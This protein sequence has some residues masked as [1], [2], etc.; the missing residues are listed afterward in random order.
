MPKFHEYQSKP[1]GYIQTSIDGTPQTL[2]VSPSAGTLLKELGFEYG[3]YIPRDV[4]KPLIIVGT[5]GTKPHGRT[6]WELLDGIPELSTEYCELNESQQEKLREYL[7]QRVGDL[8]EPVFDR[9]ATFIETE[10]PLESFSQTKISIKETAEGGPAELQIPPTESD[11]DLEAI[12]AELRRA[13]SWLCWRRETRDSKPTKVPISPH[14]GEFG[15]VNDESTW[16]SLEVAVDA[17]SRDGIDGL[18]FVFTEGNTVA[19]IDL[20]HIRNPESGD[21]SSKATDIIETLDSYTEVSPSGTGV[22]V[23]VKG[24]I[25]DG[26]QRHDGVELYDS[27]RFFTVTSEHLPD[28]PREIRVR[29]DELAVVHEEYVSRDEESTP[30]TTTSRPNQTPE[31]PKPETDLN[32]EEVITYGHRNQKFRQLWNGKTTGYPSHS[33]ADMALCVLLAYYTGDDKSLMDT[34]FRRSK[35]MRDKWDE[36]RGNQTYGELTLEK[37][38]QFVDS[39]DPHLHGVDAAAP[40]TPIGQLDTEHK[41]TLEATVETVESVPAD[42]IDQAGELAD[43]TGQIRFVVWDSEYWDLEEEFTEGSTYRLADAWITEYQGQRQVHINEHTA[44]E[45]H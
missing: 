17:L 39:Y 12:P 24:F 2:H 14:D 13:D 38:I 18:G 40:H 7:H 43:D 27:D 15:K 31:I 22:H 21:L 26:R 32:A 28:T 29:H 10:S 16:A 3:D 11:I 8:S 33:E 44:V 25:P 4:T 6:K 9:L 34:V 41:A 20:D 35:L 5:I 30:P 19:G 45:E 1:G 36:L 37:A 42:T 23:L